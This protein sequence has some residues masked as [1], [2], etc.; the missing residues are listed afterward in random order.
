[1]TPATLFCGRYLVV[2]RLGSG[3]S[4]T[5]FLAEDQRLG[6]QVAVKRLHGAEVTETTAER[7]RREARI[8]ASL[9]HPNLVTVLDMLT[10]D[11]DLY[12]V[13]EYVP[14]GTLDDVLKDAPLEPARV[15]ELLRPVAAALD[16]AH[17]HD[18]VHRDVK[19]SNVLVTDGG[20]VK[21]CDLGLA[22]AAEITRITPPGSI[23]GTPAYM[24]P[25]QAQPVPC[26]PATDIF[27][28]ATIAFEALSGTRPRTG[29]TAMAVLRQATSM[30]PP[31]LRER[32][33]ETPAGAAEALMRGMALE[34]GERQHS[35]AALLDELEAGLGAPQPTRRMPPVRRERSPADVLAAA[36]PPAPAPPRRRM[37]RLLAVLS[38]VVVAAAVVAV[39][40]LAR[41]TD[42]DQQASSTP[43]PTREA[44]AEATREPTSEPTEEATPAA[45]PRALGPAATVRAFYERAA[46]DDFAGAWRLAGPRM[47]A[48]YGNSEA[49]FERQLGSLERIEFAELALDARS[50][51]TATV[52]VRTVAT[53]TDRVDRCTGTLQTTRSGGRWQVEPA[54]LSCERG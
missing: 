16:H 11:D 9:R 53:H 30:P 3:G 24:A 39:L 52:R 33:P 46:E 43:E 37:G 28:L 25:E 40:A 13:M 20:A 35:A 10:E 48:V 34:P 54:G 29:S 18:V 15:L 38:L 27:A 31:D 32:R 17:A 4:A 2:R 42:P 41:G 7:L 19:P 45:T 6:R 44:N 14:G 47:R 21:L 12:L 22:T 1:M 26:T 50:G 8:M 23:L 5:V 36:D 51:S 49:E